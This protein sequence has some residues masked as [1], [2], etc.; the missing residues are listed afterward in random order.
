MSTDDTPRLVSELATLSQ[1][2]E[3]LKTQRA[4]LDATTEA[5]KRRMA[6]IVDTTTPEPYTISR[7]SELIGRSRT[8]LAVITA[9][10]RNS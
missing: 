8:W 7:L 1:R 10:Y 6:A 4:A 2:L 9:P 3:S 5:V